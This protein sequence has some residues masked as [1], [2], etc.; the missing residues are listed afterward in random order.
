MPAIRAVH[1]RRSSGAHGLASLSPR[2]RAARH[3]APVRAAAAACASAPSG[4]RATGPS[5]GARNTCACAADRSRAQAGVGGRARLRRMT[6]VGVARRRIRRKIEDRRSIQDLAVAYPAGGALGG[7]AGA[8]RTGSGR[9][10]QADCR[11]SSARSTGTMQQAE[12]RVGS[13]AARPARSPTIGSTWRRE[14]PNSLS[15]RT[16]PGPWRR[17][18]SGSRSAAPH[19]GAAWASAARQGAQADAPAPAQS[20]SSSL[21]PVLERVFASTRLTITAQARLGPP[22]FA[23]SVPGTTTE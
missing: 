11:P 22:S 20:R 7:S 8:S 23:G 1:C 4:P 10:R 16:P 14:S 6:A 21:I 3:A 9:S 18:R 15:R 5:S 13:P 2:S 12:R 17:L 19:A